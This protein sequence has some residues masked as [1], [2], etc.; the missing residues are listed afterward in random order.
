MYTFLFI[1]HDIMLSFNENLKK[2][3]LTEVLVVVIFSYMIVFSLRFFQIISLDYAVSNLIVLLF[4]IFKLK[5]FISELKLDAS[6]IFSAVSFWE[7]LVIVMLNIFFSY[8]MLY[9]SDYIAH[10]IPPESYLSFLIPA[11]SI[12]GGLAGV[13]SLLSVILISPPVEEMLF[14]GIFLNK[15]KMIVPVTFAVL[16]SS[17]LFASLHSFGSILSAFVFGICM[18]L[19][20]LKTDNILVPILTH[21]INN[22]LSEAI[23]HLDYSNLLFTNGIVM[24]VML[25]LAIVSFIVLFRFMK[26]NLKNI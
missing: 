14:R 3:S 25:G 15:M 8:G 9:L 13:L 12:G 22:L 5:D 6:N 24:T 19:L 11:K 1:F 7:I 18:A 4:F 20:Y 10:S 16:M 26:S 2:I 23:Y 21:F 17:L